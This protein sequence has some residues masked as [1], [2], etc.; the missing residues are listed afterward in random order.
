MAN[1]TKLSHLIDPQVLSD[2]MSVKLV[3]EIKFSPIA[4]IDRTLVGRA[5][6]TLS[7]PRYAY[8]GTATDIAELEAMTY[9]ELTASF[10][11]VKVKK[12]G[13]GVKV[14]D[15]AMLS[16][17]GDTQGEI[18]RQL[19][20]SIATKVDNDIL[21]CLDNA[22][23][24]SPAVTVTPN[25]VNDALVKFGEDVEGLKFLFVSPQTYAVLRQSEA[26]VPASE[27]AARMVISGTVGEI[28]GCQ[29][30]ITNKISGNQTAYIVK[31]GA[32]RIIMK[33]AIQ[34][35]S[36]RDIDYKM[37]K[38]N[39]DE[40][41]AAWLYDE[42]KVVKIGSAE[43]GSLTVTQTTNI[44]SSKAKFKVTG[45][46]TNLSAGWKAYYA[47]NLNSAATP[48]VGDAYSTISAT[49]D[50][51]YAGEIEYGATNAK[52]F[53]VV[54][55]DADSKVRATGSVAAATSLA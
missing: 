53:Q 44:S 16:A 9:A 37:T 1:E 22:T 15:E 49:F 51:E 17:Y 30:V 46:P 2:F 36:A 26:W 39:A 7:V 6:D 55:I 33:R 48:S 25:A 3:N 10:Q 38:I 27:I 24:V 20:L 47:T 40:H 54:Y 28:Y 12:A 21:A 52:Y 11:D 42:S 4:V 32:V 45:W 5:G 29:V 41:Y 23:W 31:P 43:L 18:S 19:L 13:R 50:K 35:E 8:I 14:S 34:V